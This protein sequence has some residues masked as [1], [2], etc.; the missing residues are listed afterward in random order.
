MLYRPAR[1]SSAIVGVLLAVNS[2]S[3]AAQTTVDVEQLVTR[4]LATT[5]EYEKTFQNL[6]AE[7]TKT[8]EVFDNAGKMEKRRLMVSDLLVYRSPGDGRA[9]TEYRDVKAVD[10][11]VIENRRERAMKL[12][13]RAAGAKTLEKELEAIHRETSQYEFH[14]QL[15][16]YTIHQGGVFKRHSAAFAV[17]M[18]GRERMSG[19]DVVVL[20]YKQTAHIPGF[21]LPLPKEFGNAP[22]RH[23][24]RLWLDAE[25]G[26]S[27][28]EVWELIASHPA[29]AEPLVML[30]E[31][32]VYN[33]SRFGIL[34]PQRIVFE[35]FLR[36]S[37]PKKGQPTFELA[38]RTTF[39]Y[40][41][42]RRFDVTTGE[43]IRVP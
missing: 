32:R 20:D 22:R 3:G 2:L 18:A 14:R 43:S 1:V 13:T 21:L 34:V 9:T 8:I 24:G 41:A 16:G 10:G 35:W 31:E 26:Q 36:F 15:R 11:K 30:R 39:T 42:F 25:T 28:R 12:V 29:V 38:E 23:R 33:P 17:T 19:R 40:D 4:F 7:E 6:V 27:W 5:D 37:H